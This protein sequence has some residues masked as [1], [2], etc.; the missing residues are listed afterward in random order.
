MVSAG[1]SLLR[2]LLFILRVI[3]ALSR[4]VFCVLS[5]IC[6]FAAAGEPGL[7]I[8]FTAFYHQAHTCPASSGD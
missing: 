8:S 6:V 7:L 2:L 5:F 1:R 3:Q 4:L